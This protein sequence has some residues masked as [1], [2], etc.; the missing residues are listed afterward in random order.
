[1]VVAFVITV[2]SLRSI[3]PDVDVI[4]IL[5]GANDMLRSV[6]PD[7][8]TPDWYDSLRRRLQVY[9]EA[10]AVPLRPSF[11]PML[12]RTESVRR[13]R[14]T[15]TALRRRVG[16]IGAEPLD[17]RTY[18][19]ARSR[20]SSATRTL[21]ALPD[22]SVPLEAYHHDLRRLVASARSQGI[23][24]VFITQPALWADPT[25]PEADRLL[26]MGEL[27]DTGGAAAGAYY[28]PVALAA[29][30][31]RFNDVMTQVCTEESVHCIDLASIVAADTVAFYDDVHFN[32]AGGAFVARAL[33]DSLV[34]LLR[35][36]VAQDP[37]VAAG[38]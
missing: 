23:E 18:A 13:A 33:A 7:L 25:P 9:Y 16:S 30:L 37:G 2:E 4:T 22:L 29:G 1:V 24:V 28:S 10:F 5:A 12:E 38:R 26:W 31:A 3:L 36:R 35:Q 11:G 15:F 14:V 21:D 34:P 32:E 17:G 6:Q 20:R 27:N 8:G 19:A